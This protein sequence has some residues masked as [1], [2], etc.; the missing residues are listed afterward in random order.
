MHIRK[1]I[2][3]IDLSKNKLE[4]SRDLGLQSIQFQK[5]SLEL[6]R[7]SIVERD[8]F[9]CRDNPEKRQI[10]DEYL[11]TLDKMHSR[12]NHERQRQLN[13]LSENID[14]KLHNLSIRQD[15]LKNKYKDKFRL[16]MQRVDALVKIQAMSVDGQLLS[17]DYSNLASVFIGIDSLKHKESDMINV[18]EILL[19]V[20][21]DI[22]L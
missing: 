16:F 4:K 14:K 18:E 3:S 17:N 20:E 19:E 5:S 8:L 6:N 15:E 12:L 13:N 1:Q 21:K 2:T 9:N 7:N 22:E 11:N 10:V